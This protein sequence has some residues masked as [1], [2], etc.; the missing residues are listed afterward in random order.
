MKPFTKN[1]S[2]SLVPSADVFNLQAILQRDGYAT[3]KPYG[4]IGPKTRSAIAS[5]QREHN[6]KPALG[7]F[8][9]Q[10]RL[11]MNLLNFPKQQIFHDI[12]V[13]LLNVDASPQDRAPDFLGCADTVNMVYLEALGK[14][15]VSNLVSTVQLYDTLRTDSKR[16]RKTDTIKAGTIVISHTVGSNVGHVSIADT[17]TQLMSNSSSSGKF[18]RN[19]TVDSWRKYFVEGKKLSME[20]YDII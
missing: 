12:A 5:F 13:S 1:L 10:T 9:S 4:F 11:K 15:I 19:Y 18:M 8:G 17:A 7:N 20:Y 2:E 14:E 6:I 16:F 3:F